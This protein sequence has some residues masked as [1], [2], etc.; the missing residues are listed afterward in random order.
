MEK[1]K[2]TK[3]YSQN[4]PWTKQNWL[5]DHLPTPVNQKETF[6]TTDSA[7]AVTLLIMVHGHLSG[8]SLV[9][10]FRVHLSGGSL[11]RRF[12][13]PKVHLSVLIIY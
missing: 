10:S 1:K 8:D 5:R 2:N 4:I 6:T 13:C 3:I 9:R 12:V 7:E 11:V